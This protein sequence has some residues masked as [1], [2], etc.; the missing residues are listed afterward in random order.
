MNLF[1]FLM[2]SFVS[3]VTFASMAAFQQKKI[4]TNSSATAQRVY[5]DSASRQFIPPPQPSQRIYS[6]SGN[7]VV[8][9][10][11]TGVKYTTVS[12]AELRISK[13]QRPLDYEVIPIGRSDFQATLVADRAGDV[14]FVIKNGAE[15]LQS[16]SVSLAAT[17]ASVKITLNSGGWTL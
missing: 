3:L 4:Y 16:G 13:I 1:Y 9:D 6:D 5:S 12:N 8:K 2:V 14:Q 11:K 15:T 17:T 7:S 10:T